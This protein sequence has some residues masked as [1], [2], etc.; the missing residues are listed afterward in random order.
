MDTSIGT[1]TDPGATEYLA[2]AGDAPLRNKPL[3]P[4]LRGLPGNVAHQSQSSKEVCRQSSSAS[5]CDRRHAES[6]TSTETSTKVASLSTVVDEE[7]SM[8]IIA[9][10]VT[11]RDLAELRSLRFPPAVVCQVLEAVAVLLGITDTRW[12][13]M[14]KLL[15]NGFV[16]RISAFDPSTIT[17]A[18][19]DRLKV[20]LQVPTFSDSSLYER[21]PSIASLA[22]W[23]NAVG[24]HLAELA[25][26]SGPCPSVV[27][28]ELPA[29]VTTE[30]L[31]EEP[32]QL[33]WVNVTRPDLG[34]LDVTPDLWTLPEAE[35]A[36]VQ[37][38]RVS[39]EGVGSV[40][41]HGATD[42]REF[43]KS[44][45]LGEVVILNPGEVVVYP[46]QKMKPSVGQGL[47]KFS[48]I[49]LYGCLPKT[50]GFKDKK[51]RDRYKK[52]VRQMT[53]EKGADFVDYDGEKGIWQFNVAHF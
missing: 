42:C 18:Q 50:H 13:K 32:P 27:E 51:A 24:R 44:P 25:K 33:A 12:P 52:R 21:C 15:D 31:L 45:V 35:L 17:P 6:S 38:L 29:D 11:L 16:D 30:P 53:E 49:V 46:N 10:R 43:I 34:G 23:C 40:T 26:V 20:L 4:R 3:Q 37:E 48:T 19:A 2:D 14:R 8:S 36:H 47:N 39:R 41:F 7:L 22:A 9:R 1:Q 5:A 28:A